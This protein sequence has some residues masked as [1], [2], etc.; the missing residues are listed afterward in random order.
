MSRIRSIKPDFFLDEDLSELSFQDRIAFIG[1]WCQADREGRLE[2][3]PKYLKALIFPYD[4]SK[5]NECLDRLSNGDKPFINRYNVDNRGYIQIN[6]F[7]KH[8]RPH[9]TE[10]ESTFPPLE[11]GELTVIPL[12][13]KVGKGKEKGKVNGKGIY[14]SGV[15][16]KL[17][18]ITKHSFKNTSSHS[19]Y[20]KARINEGY[21][22]EDFES[23][24]EYKK[25]EWGNDPKMRKFLRPETLFGTKFDSYLQESKMPKEENPPNQLRYYCPKH[26]KIYIRGETKIDYYTCKECGERLVLM[27]KYVKEK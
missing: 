26:P 8:Q 10:K 6:N 22:L 14:S 12:I 3:R 25:D 18:S 24:I 23:V 13:K 27:D 5:M 20:I 1:L 21:S 11:D 16:K 9:H 15:I 17:N 19:G 7:L 2:D 4:N